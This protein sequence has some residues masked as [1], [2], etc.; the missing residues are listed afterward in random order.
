MDNS[1]SKR[2]QICTDLHD[3]L[4]VSKVALVVTA[5]QCNT[6]RIAALLALLSPGSPY[7]IEPQLVAKLILLNKPGHFYRGIHSQ[8]ADFHSSP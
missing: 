8:Q 7:D 6:Q 4:Q 1:A 2:G 3:I 5:T